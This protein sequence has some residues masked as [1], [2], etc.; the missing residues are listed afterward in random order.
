MPPLR[1]AARKGQPPVKRTARESGVRAA[2]ARQRPPTK[3]TKKSGESATE[4]LVAVVRR[5][6]QLALQ[7]LRAPSGPL[8]VATPGPSSP[9]DSVPGSPCPPAAAS[10]QVP[11]V[12]DPLPGPSSDDHNATMSNILTDFLAGNLP[13]ESQGQQPLPDLPHSPLGL[14]VSAKLKSRI[15]TDQYV[16][17][18]ELLPSGSDHPQPEVSISL[19]GS[20]ASVSST[21]VAKA[22]VSVEQW[23]DAWLVFASVYLERHPAEAVGIL[24]YAE[25]I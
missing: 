25:S 23:T 7:G 12:P 13:G 3:T 8:P 22:I 9:T 19:S 14:N 20:T 4:D 15:V 24:R 16:E 5:E 21:R 17:L 2:E 6:V 11:S 18:S 10:L 1:K